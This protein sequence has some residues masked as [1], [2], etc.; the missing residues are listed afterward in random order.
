MPAKNCLFCT[1]TNVVLRGELAYV[2]TDSYP[3]NPGHL[4]IIPNRHVAGF[5]ELR[6]D[7]KQAMFDLLEEAK[8]YLDREQGPDGYNF[9]IN[10]GPAAGQSVMHVH[11]HLI[12]RYLGDMPDPR[13]GVRGVIP[14]KQ[15]YKRR[16]RHGD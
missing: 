15:K 1:P 7:E 12:P 4:L 8:A 9:G 3:V 11:L 14:E 13:G 10:I 16:P 6:R 5:F 2:R